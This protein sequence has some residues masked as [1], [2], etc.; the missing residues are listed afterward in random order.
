MILGANF[1]AKEDEELLSLLYK[2]SEDAFSVIF[3]RYNKLLYTLA[4][5]YLKSDDSAKNAVQTVFM[6]L[7]ES[8]SILNISIN[9]RN[10]LYT[11]LKNYVLNEIRNN[12]LAIEKNYEIARS[13]QENEDDTFTK[14]ANKDMIQRLYEAIKKL[15]AQKRLIC[16]LKLQGDLSNQEIAD[17]MHLSVPTVKTH[18]NQAI[19]MLREYFTKIIIILCSYFFMN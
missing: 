14:L 12:N 15:P 18:Y 16:Q 8:R 3:N 1:N 7:W 9:L 4:F 2:G 6:K 19:K 5:N 10:Y 13:M 11:M 17:K